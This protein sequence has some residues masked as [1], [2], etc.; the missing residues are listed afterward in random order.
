MDERE[1]RLAQNEALFREVNEKVQAVATTHGDDD[2]V[3][4]FYCECSNADCTLQVPATIAA[5]EAVRE[6]PDRFLIFPRHALPDIET[7]LEETPD[8]WVIE[9]TGEAGSYVSRLDPRGR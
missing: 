1:R 3:Y 5:Y 8:W 6:H 7:V 4:E 9:K 2:H